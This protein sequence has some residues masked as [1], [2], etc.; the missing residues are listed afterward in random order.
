MMCKQEQNG[1]AASK[2]V[3]EK[4]KLGSKEWRPKPNQNKSSSNLLQRSDV[5]LLL[6]RSDMTLQQNRV[7]DKTEESVEEAA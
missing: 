1:V 6:Q 3:K 5:P 4:A 2:E 7:K